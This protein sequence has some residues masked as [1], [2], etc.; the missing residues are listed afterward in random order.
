MIFKPDSINQWWY[1]TKLDNKWLSIEL[2]SVEQNFHTWS[3]ATRAAYEAAVKAVARDSST[4]ED[5]KVV[6]AKPGEC[7]ELA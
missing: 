3:E 2:E 6:S 5:S 1:M 7:Y 4:H